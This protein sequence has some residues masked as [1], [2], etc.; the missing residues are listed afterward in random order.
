M[1]VQV[2]TAPVKIVSNVASLVNEFN[3]KVSKKIAIDNCVLINK[4]ES[5]SLWHHT[6]GHAP[7]SKL[8]YIEVVPSANTEGVYVICLIAKMFKLPFFIKVTLPP[9]LCLSCCI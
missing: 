8:K 7:V 1:S 5:F 4:Q 2:T 3:H 6:L 9:L